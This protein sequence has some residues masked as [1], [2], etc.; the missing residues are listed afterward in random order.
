MNGEKRYEI[1][2]R[3]LESLLQKRLGPETRLLN[4][5]TSPFTK[6]GDN[7]GSTMLKVQ[8]TIEKSAED[9]DKPTELNLVAKMM[10]PT[11]IQRKIFQSL[12]TFK[13]EIF[14][15][16]ELLP[17]YEEVLGERLDIVPAVFGSRLSLKPDS[18]EV[19]D[20]AVILMENMKLKGY[21]MAD[22][23]QGNAEFT[24]YFSIAK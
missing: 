10:P 21:Y 8:A 20:D 3:D 11:D 7:Y 22:R 1:V 12:F 4:Y 16:D 15:Y 23:F 14:V 24:D 18:D 17:K 5:D 2:L 6:E 19:D 13:K 9:K